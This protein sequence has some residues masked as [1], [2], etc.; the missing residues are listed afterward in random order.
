MKEL[1]WQTVRYLAS[2]GMSRADAAVA[3]GISFNSLRGLIV[4]HPDGNPFA[5]KNL[6]DRIKSRWG[7]P[8][9]QLLNDFADQGLTRK[10]AAQALGV[11]YSAI[12]EHLVKDDPFPDQLVASS[13]VRES[14]E[15]L[16]A[17]VA[18][19]VSD[20]MTGESMARAIGFSNYDSLKRSLRSRGIDVPVRQKN[21]KPGP[22]IKAVK[23]SSKPALTKAHPWR[24]AE[25]RSWKERQ[26]RLVNSIDKPSAK[27]A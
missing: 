13:Y 27:S 5:S 14:G 7:L 10:Q 15:T 18:R 3:M 20:G 6:P 23:P 2:N 24:I 9:Q 1:M 17:A 4:S 11:S 16:R 19:M 12:R 26:E 21:P 8:L 25:N 22:R